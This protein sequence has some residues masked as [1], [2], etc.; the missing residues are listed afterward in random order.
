MLFRSAGKQFNFTCH[1]GL[2]CFAI[3]VAIDQK[4]LVILGGRS[5]ASTSEYTAFLHR[6]E[7]LPAVES[8]DC[9]KNIKFIDARELEQA[10][11]VPSPE[12]SRSTHTF[13][14]TVHVG[15][16]TETIRSSSSTSSSSRHEEPDI[17]RMFA[18]AITAMSGGSGS[19][20]LVQASL[21]VVVRWL[22]K[23]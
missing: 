4:Q 12:L 5:F 16:R 11:A 21:G 10:A 13:S 14:W 3:P 2:H 20:S 8:G 15:N 17:D 22:G 18:E 1:A 23:T 9:L 6:Y 7:D 19:K